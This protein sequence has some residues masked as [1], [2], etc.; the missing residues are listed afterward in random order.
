MPACTYPPEN[1]RG[2]DGVDVASFNLC[3]GTEVHGRG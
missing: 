3:R 1:G 2:V